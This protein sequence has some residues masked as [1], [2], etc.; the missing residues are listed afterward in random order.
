MF[1]RISPATEGSRSASSA[2]A[3][4]DETL[5]KRKTPSTFD[6]SCLVTLGRENRRTTFMASP[7]I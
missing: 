6:T 3:A 7:T 5:G 1:P 4:A 2:E